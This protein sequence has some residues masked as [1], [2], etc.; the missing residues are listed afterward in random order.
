MDV[1][2]SQ[3]HIWKA[4]HPE[5]PWVPGAKAHLDTPIGYEDLRVMM[6]E[7]G[8]NRAVLVP[9]GWEGG[10]LDF[11]FEAASR[12]PEQFAVMGHFPIEKKEARPLLET[13]LDQPGM[14]G[15]RLYFREKQRPWLRDGTADW[16]WPAAERLGI[17]LMVNAPT[18]IPEIGEVAARYPGLPIIIDHMG[19][20]DAKDDA[21]APG[22]ERALA[23]AHLS[24]VHLKMTLVPSFSSA[25]Y[26]YRN[27]HPY[28]KRL[29]DAFTPQRCFWGTDFSAMATR[30]NCTYP[31]SVTMFTREMDFLSQDDIAWIMGRGLAQCLGWTTTSR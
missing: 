2:D 4:D 18:A 30:S 22:V 24:N 8:V 23:L 1:I 20:R 12:Y 16:F 19:L 21:I 28:L 27:I 10:R 17:P 31:Q 15:I 25:P 29:V 3:V 9:P 6:A 7:A 14:L 26:P 5:R 11:C 13:W